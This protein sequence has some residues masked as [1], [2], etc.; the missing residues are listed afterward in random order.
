MAEN[1]RDYDTDPEMSNIRKFVRRA[2][3]TMGVEFD[4]F[5]GERASA[6]SGFLSAVTTA[7]A[8]IVSAVTGKSLHVRYVY[9]A[10]PKK[11]TVKFHNGNTTATKFA[12]RCASGSSVN[13]DGVCGPVFTG[14]I[15][16]SFS[17]AATT[18][19]ISIGGVRDSLDPSA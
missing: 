5:N 7:N 2:D 10:S 14:A 3:G 11:A 16:V 19:T 17:S 9:I 1:S 13:V 18:A 8:L 15:Y 12:I 4:Q 6:A